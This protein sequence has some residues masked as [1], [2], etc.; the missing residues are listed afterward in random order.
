M[1][2]SQSLLKIK[3]KTMDTVFLTVGVYLVP[4]EN[5]RDSILFFFPKFF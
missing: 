5:S 2:T 4:K 3:V 1:I